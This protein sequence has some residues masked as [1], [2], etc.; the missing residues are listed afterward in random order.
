MKFLEMLKKTFILLLATFFIGVTISSEYTALAKD[1]KPRDWNKLTSSGRLRS[2]ATESSYCVIMDAHTGKVLY[3]ENANS[4]RYPASITKIMTT[5]VVLENCDIS[6]YVTIGDVSVKDKGAQKIG[7]RKNEVIKVE[8]LLY[9]FMLESGNDAGVALAKYAAGSVEEFAEMMNAKAEEIGM[10]RTRFANPHGLHESRHYTTAMDMAIL[11]YNAM[12]NPTFRKIVGTFKYTPPVTNKHNVERPW[13]PKVWKNH[14][15]LI[16]TDKDEDFAFNDKNGHAIG[17]KT[18]YTRAAQST[19]VS[20]AVSKDGTQEVITVV[21]YDTQKGKW[22][23]TITMFMYAFD[24]YDTLN[25]SKYLARDL[26]ITAHVENAASSINNENLE[27]FLIPQKNN[28]ITDTTEQIQLIKDNPDS[29]TRVDEIKTLVAPIKKDEEVGVSK[30]YLNGGAEPVL[31]CTLIAAH[32][33]DPI[34]IGGSEATPTQKPK[35]PEA[36]P[37]PTD[38]TGIIGNIGY[39]LLV[40]VGILLIITFIVMIRRK[41]KYHQYNVSTRG[42]HRRK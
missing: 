15:R 19:L 21:L 1:S 6:Q 37:E 7:L 24:F 5:L 28:Y 23:D 14:N 4:K 2:S 30:F 8:D 10:T 13:Y 11:A 31:T 34:P 41:A 35:E 42:R 16:S 40:V 20:A 36:T 22:T 17:I 18:G 26:T 32:D 29:F 39:A 33:V 3:Q 27:M 25:L 9:G 38:E 12:K